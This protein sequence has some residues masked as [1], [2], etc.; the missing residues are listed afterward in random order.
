MGLS[1]WVGC[2][3]CYTEGHLI[4]YW[5]DLGRA[6]PTTAAVHHRQ[7]R[8]GEG[9]DASEHEELG[10]FDL[11][12]DLAL[13]TNEIGESLQAAMQVTEVL[14]EVEPGRIAA[15]A[16]YAAAADETVDT[17]LVKQFQEQCVGA[18]ES[19]RDFGMEYC[20]D[21]I[22]WESLPKEVQQ[23][24]APHLDWEGI[25]QEQLDHGGYDAAYVGQTLYVWHES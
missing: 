9:F 11:D 3:R 13:F 8:M 15:F 21:L 16:A 23:A 22:G 4:G 18:Y 20:A 6:E 25:G 17:A 1:A 2:W 24:L 19:V 5:F 14:A 7:R 12:G 10:V